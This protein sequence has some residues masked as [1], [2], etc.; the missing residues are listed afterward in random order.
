MVI[1]YIWVL[2]LIVMGV[3]VGIFWM[4]WWLVLLWWVLGFGMILGGVMGNLVDCFFWVLGL[5]CGYV[6][7]FLLVGWWLVFNVVDLLVVGGVILLV[8][9]L[10]FG[11]DFDIVGW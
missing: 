8:I 1:G 4:G 11:F 10:I 5:L 3:V 7:D 2:M 6:V 9:L